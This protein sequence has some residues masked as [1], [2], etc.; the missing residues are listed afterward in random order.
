MLAFTSGTTLE[1]GSTATLSGAGTIRVGGATV[2]FAG[3]AAITGTLEI[4]TGVLNFNGTGTTANMTHSGGTLGGTGALTVSGTLSWTGGTQTGAG[5]TTIAAT[6]TGTID[7]AT[8][9]V[10]LI[11]GRTLQNNGTITWLSGQIN[12]ADSVLEN[13]GTFDVKG[14]D[15]YAFAANPQPRIHNTGTFKKTGGTGTTEIQAAF[16]ND[17]TV[18]ASSGTLGLG[19]GSGTETGSGTFSADA[20]AV[21]AFTSGTTLEAGSTA[22]LSGAGTIR[23]GGATVNFAG[24]AAITGTL[25]ITTG[26]LNFNG[27]GTTANMT[28]SGGTLGG[29]GALTVSGTLS[30]TGGT[31]T[32]AGTTTIAATA[33]G[34]IDSATTQVALIGGRTLQN[35]G[36]ITWLSGQINAADSVL[37]NAGTFDV[38]GDDIYAFAA[39]PQPR[40]HNTGTFKKTGGTGTT[41]I[42]AAFDNDGTVTASSGTLGLGGGSG[43]E[44]GSGTFSADAGAVLAFT[45][46]TTLE[47]GSTAT[48]SGA[49]TIRVGGAT[50]NFAGSAAITGT[51]EITTGVLNFNGTGTTANMTH[52]GGT[53]GGT[54]ALT[55]SG[56][57]SWTGGTQT[58]AGT[59]TIAATATGTIDSATTQVALIGGRTL[60]NNGTITW[61]SGQINA[62][63]SV[64]ENAGTFDVKGDDIYAFA[65]NP[66]PRI[67][68]TG[69]FKKTG[70]TGTTEIQAAFDNDGTVEIATG[71]IGVSSYTQS[72]TGV[73]QVRI[74][75]TT[76]GTGFGSAR[77]RKRDRGA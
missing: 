30:W 40:I 41:E 77:G 16:D 9:Q 11:G 18:T 7:S 3:S 1:A 37:E 13:A 64:L 36:T 25:E 45:S 43:T 61:L 6:A 69:T 75:G 24:S 14:D 32:G 53:L 54:G 72:S 67:H 15:I 57:L 21:L 31:Q 68:N 74:A 34:T 65:A 2:N 51:L 44:T 66:Q 55:V 49:G 12:A 62:A 58:G 73:L 26:V 29:T 22:T 35:N 39:N 20:G 52:S 48:L 63:D 70:G 28:H 59:T 23:V 46:G 50:V 76:P 4:T 17:G 71:I 60:Q 10:A 42:Q 33:T 38:K 27:T 56:T 8:T 47:A 19:G 5:T